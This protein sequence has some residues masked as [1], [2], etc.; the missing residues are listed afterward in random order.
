MPS[1]TITQLERISAADLGAPPWQPLP[2]APPDV[3]GFNPSFA[4]FGQGHVAAQYRFWELINE[5]E[6]IG[7]ITLPSSAPNNVIIFPFRVPQ[8]ASQQQ[9]PVSIE[10]NS[11]APVTT[12]YLRIATTGDLQLFNIPTTG[13]VATKCSFHGWYSLDA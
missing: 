12:P 8:P 1:P 10:G 5:V 6:L 9:I 2:L 11:V 3:I 4:N 13:T 7:V